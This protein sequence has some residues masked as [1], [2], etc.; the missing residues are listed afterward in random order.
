M[1]PQTTLAELIAREYRQRLVVDRLG[2]EVYSLPNPAASPLL[3]ELAAAEQ[4]LSATARGRARLQARDPRSGLVLDTSRGNNLLGPRTTGLEIQVRMRMAQVP[5]SI[6]HLLDRQEHPLVAYTVHNARENRAA[7]LRI[8]SFIEGYS[9][10]AVDT[11]E[12]DPH[13]RPAVIGQFPILF[14]ERLR[15]VTEL[16]RATLHTMVEDIDEKLELHQTVPVWLLARTTAPLAVLDPATGQWQDMTPYFGAFVTPN[17]PPIMAFLRTVAGL[18]PRERLVGYQGGKE[19]VEPQV[20]AVFEALKQANITYIHSV[21]SFIPERDM[22]TQR[23]RL[24]RESL[25][26]GEANCIDGTVLFASLLEAISLSPAL[27]IV[28]GHAL[29]AWETADGNGEWL[30]L[31]TTMISTSSFD[32]ACTSAGETA[33]LYRSLAQ[34]TQ[35]PELFRQWPLRVL[36]TERGIT[37]ME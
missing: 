33:E 3:P 15:Q 21:I 31:E 4:A 13:K 35:S 10:Q 20:R 22:T 37:P 9:A 14:P 32:D 29:V 24:P 6:A 28:P 25:A 11:V 19:V 18:H 34:T 1:S 16:T 17:A 2:Q 8:T 26:G 36:R 30:Y 27:V 5:T 23:V 7:R 12:L